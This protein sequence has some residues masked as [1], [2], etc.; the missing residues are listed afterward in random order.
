VA[1]PAEITD[2]NVHDIVLEFDEPVDLNELA[3]VLLRDGE[4]VETTSAP[5][6][7]PLGVADASAPQGISIEPI[8]DLH[9]RIT[10]L[11]SYTGDA[12]DYRLLLNMNNVSDE[13]GNFS[14][15]S[16]EITWTRVD[17]A[18]IV[19]D[20]VGIETS[21]RNAPVHVVLVEFS[22]PLAAGSFTRGDISLV[23]DDGSNLI[24]DAV[25]VVRV[26]ATHFLVEGLGALTATDGHYSLT[27]DA[28]GVTDVDG[29]M[30]YGQ[31]S[32]TWTMDTAAPLIVPVADFPE[33]I[34]AYPVERIRFEVSEPVR[35]ESLGA[36]L[37]KL[38]R[39][40]AEVAL[41]DTIR[42]GALG[43]GRY[44]VDGLTSLTQEGGEYEL[45]VDGTQMEDLAGNAGS[46]ASITWNHDVTPP[47]A[48]IIFGLSADTDT[49]VFTND[50][51][52]R[53]RDVALVGTTDEPYLEIEIRDATT[54]GLLAEHTTEGSS[55]SIPLA[56]DYL[57]A[58]EL[59]VTL[60][61]YAGNITT[62][63][64]GLY[65]DQMPPYVDSVELIAPP[66]PDLPM[67]IAVRFTENVNLRQ[68]ID[69]G[70]IQDAAYLQDESGAPLSIPDASFS[71]DAD[72]GILHVS[73]GDLPDNSVN[74][75]TL[76]L[77]G[78]AITDLAGN[79]LVGGHQ[80][81]IREPLG[82]RESVVLIPAMTDETYSVPARGDVTGDGLA[83]LIVGA[84]TTPETGK[85]RVYPNTGEL[86][87]PR[88]GDP[89]FL[90]VAGAD[91]EVPASGCL[92]V[93]PRVFDWNRDGLADVVL[94]HSNG[95]I[96][97][98]ENIGTAESPVFAELQYVRVAG[99]DLNVGERATFDM[100]DWNE[101]GRFDLVTGN[102]SG[103]VY[104]LLNRA[105]SGPAQFASLESVLDVNGNPLAVPTGRASVDVVDLDADG[106][107]DL[108]VGNTSGQLLYYRNT[109][110]EGSPSFDGYA[111]LV[112][113]TGEIDLDG[114][115]R[116][117]PF[118]TDHNSD[119]E[120]DLL[121]GAFDGSVRL[122][123]GSPMMLEPAIQYSPNAGTEFVYAFNLPVS[124]V[125]SLTPTPSGFVAEFGHPIDPT[126]ISLY[127]VEAEVWGAA[128][129]VLT[130]DNVGVVPGSL[131]VEDDRVTFVATGDVL[132]ADTYTVQ[133][134]GAVDGFRHRNLDTA[135]D[136]DGD[137]LPGG[138]FI[139]RFAVSGPEAVVVGLPDFVRGPG[140][141]VDVPAT[142]TGL[143]LSISDGRDIRTIDLTIRYDDT[144]LAITGAQPGPL[145]PTDATVEIDFS[146]P[147]QVVLQF[148]SP[149][150]LASGPVELVSLVAA[151]PETAS[152][153]ASHLLDIVSTQVN[154]GEVPV[155]EDDAVHSVAYFGDT[156]ANRDYSGLD[157]VQIART[158]VGLD[159][160]FEAFH[161]VDPA[162]IAD[163]TGNGDLS[164][165]D[166]VLLAREVV[167][168][169][170][171]EI[172]PLPAG[173]KPDPA[174]DA[175]QNADQFDVR[176]VDELFRSG[177]HPTLT[178]D[179][180]QDTI[181]DLLQA[182]SWL[183]PDDNQVQ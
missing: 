125:A 169:D 129:V 152:Y 156:T 95:K 16:A 17:E 4:P 86:G 46:L 138:D 133:I 36:E 47:A 61:D 44:E 176:T 182:F 76:H 10:G 50:S 72:F 166:A 183:D 130:G 85:I 79:A 141:T 13:S 114:A 41:P 42:I 123:P 92:G 35:E 131:L 38:L 93:Y 144:L 180:W 101:D 88:Y 70:E 51:L 170:P 62:F 118:A 159:R 157:A 173:Q 31:Y 172:P 59:E 146:S 49:G 39:N 181:A 126:V 80:L 111:P 22:E 162:V 27:M 135:I 100:V 139:Q 12:G 1:T 29:W 96:S 69:A 154:G 83:D 122:Y 90:Q 11:D 67:E 25:E 75:Y 60:R 63:D 24:N 6:G 15:E 78:Q 45:R 109:G 65:V 26:D 55:F 179:F 110:V 137:G 149:T 134:R 136:G 103:D 164:G 56:L 140:Q 160:G 113:P 108:V 115:S 5:Q 8:D 52:T 158:V 168:L 40:G 171:L 142:A 94:G 120:M 30:G 147:G 99:V 58:Y 104:L 112:T 19:K 54:N 87:A 14:N 116:S 18:P 161:L 77:D 7:R 2:E 28:E 145:T 127:D 174:Y 98:L 97:W 48:P 178:S 57:G 119:G 155:T 91:L 71:Y 34:T 37:L 23:R 102:Y 74:A 21:W 132:P 66:D 151:V 163:I 68:I 167:G 73:L 148:R 150:P 107:P 124:Y 105:D 9:Y 43:G 153:G 117:R 32:R 128:D 81:M 175:S 84:K 82:F 177:A 106:K 53:L 20:V 3:L 121:V 165:L 64:C 33:A 89:E 143:P